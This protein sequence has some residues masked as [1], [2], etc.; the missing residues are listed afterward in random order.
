MVESHRPRSAT[1]S[2]PVRRIAGDG[3]QSGRDALVV[4]EP[5]EIRVGLPGSP[6]DEL[7]ALAVTMRTPGH[8]FELATGFL[9]TEGIVD[10]P[11]TIRSVAYCGLPPD[12]QEYN[13]VTVRV[14]ADID[15]ERHSRTM[16][17]TSS[18][19]VCGKASIDAVAVACPDPPVGRN[20]S[21]EVVAALPTGLRRRQRWFDETGG[22]HAAGLFTGD[23]EAVQVRE[24]VGRHNAVDKVVGWAA[25]QGRLP[26][27]DTVLVVSGRASFEIVQ[28]A[29][30]AG[31]ATLV[32]VSAP[33]SLAVSAADELGV[34]VVGFARDSRF[35][36]YSHAERIGV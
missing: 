27:D 32:A 11:A 31:I 25:Q 21:P 8:D 17:T 29:A 5:L 35:T 13:I 12:E 15:L 20:V 26:L 4:E 23:G 10:D 6:D 1:L 28:K 22:L 9:I 3:T 33:S 18:C 36:I 2:V 7:S 34:T 19:G 16:Y 30:V 14:T 24:D